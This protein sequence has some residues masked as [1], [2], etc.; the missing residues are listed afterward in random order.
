VDS[1]EIASP[2]EEISI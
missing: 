2:V 1:T